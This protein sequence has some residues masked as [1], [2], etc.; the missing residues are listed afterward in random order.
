MTA[1][2]WS[3]SVILTVSSMSEITDRPSACEEFQGRRELERR[4]SAPTDLTR[5][6]HAC[7]ACRPQ[8][9]RSENVSRL[10]QKQVGEPAALLQH[11]H[12]ALSPRLLLR[13]SGSSIGHDHIFI[14][15]Q[16][17]GVGV[18][19]R[20]LGLDRFIAGHGS[21]P[22]GRRGGGSGCA[23]QRSICWGRR[24]RAVI[25]IYGLAR[26]KSAY[27]IHLCATSI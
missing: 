12:E 5:R 14:R 18:L 2:L 21:R 13:I 9:C 22:I 7:A 27:G 26:G 8:D 3:T 11:G 15:S 6:I 23:L 20:R 17:R 4:T 1:V 25:I 10:A 16:H 19:A 24:R